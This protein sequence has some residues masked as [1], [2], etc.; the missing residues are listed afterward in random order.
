MDIEKLIQTTGYVLRKY[1]GALNYTKLIKILYLSDRKSMEKTGYS[2]TG[3]AY[4]SM[5]DGPV[6]SGLY[7]LIKNKFKDRLTQYYWNSKFQTDGYDVHT[8]AAYISDGELTDLEV[9]I[10]DE[11]DRQ[12]HD[13]NYS[14]MIDYVHDKKNCPEWKNTLSSLPL[15][16]KDIFTALGF[17]SDEIKSIEEEK[18]FYKK[19]SELLDALDAPIPVH[20]QEKARELCNA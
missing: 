16:E 2:I 17:S 6:L 18:E 3:D 19:E 9:S 5:K 13:S 8:A 15:S 11:T 1:N 20:E 7:D 14:Q 12:F 4:V 10:L